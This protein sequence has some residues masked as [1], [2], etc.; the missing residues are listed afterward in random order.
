MAES[1]LSVMWFLSRSVTSH[2]WLLRW[3]SGC[4]RNGVAG[5][6]AYA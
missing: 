2:F 4:L 5:C 3:G 1:P 6:G